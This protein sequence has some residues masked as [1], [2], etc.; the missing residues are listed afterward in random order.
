M[1]TYFIPIKQYNQYLNDLSTDQ[2][3]TEWP[4][5][6]QIRGGM[7]SKASGA[8]SPVLQEKVDILHAAATALAMAFNET[9][10]GE[11]MCCPWGNRKRI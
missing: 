11:L 1:S 2:E 5:R 10:V 6:T 8:S 3:Q 9:D 7:E 4:L